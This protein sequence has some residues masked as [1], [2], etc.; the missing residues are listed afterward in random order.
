[1]RVTE[2]VLPLKNTRHCV[3]LSKHRY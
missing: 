3:V 1:M 2:I